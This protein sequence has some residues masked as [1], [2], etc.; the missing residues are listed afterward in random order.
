MN[1]LEDK[2]ALLSQLTTTVAGLTKTLSEPD[3]KNVPDSNVYK[4]TSESEDEP[5]VYKN[6]SDESDSESDTSEIPDLEEVTKLPLHLMVNEF[7][8]FGNSVDFKCVMVG[9]DDMMNMVFQNQQSNQSNHAVEIEELT[10][11]V[12]PKRVVSVDNLSD[13]KLVTEEV[14][15]EVTDDVKTLSVDL[16]YEALS[17]KELKDKVTE[18][19]GPKLKTKKE[20]LEFLKNKM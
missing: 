5:D 14:L 6:T 8:R 17:V 18:L 9:Q 12:L 16:N 13:I 4:N 7:P 15:P 20:L 10:D 19:N 2:V 1:L 3:H 11:D